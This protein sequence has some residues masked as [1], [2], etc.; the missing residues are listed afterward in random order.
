MVECEEEEEEFAFVVSQDNGN[1][2]LRWFFDSRASK[3]MTHKKQWFVNFVED[4]SR[5]EIVMVA[6]G[7]VY[8]VEGRG[9]VQIKLKNGKKCTFSNV[10]Y[11]PG[12]NK[13]L[14]SI[15]MITK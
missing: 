1:S 7:R 9:D 8:C 11:I 10:L 14:L 4:K 15:N 3:H 6:D 5:T 2:S 12:L 13:N